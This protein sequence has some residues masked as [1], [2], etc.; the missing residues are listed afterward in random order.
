MELEKLE[1]F[2]DRVMSDVNAAMSCLNLYIG[3]RLNLFQAL[4]LL[5]STDPKGLADY[6]HTNERY[7]KEWLECLAAG[8]YIDHDH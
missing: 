7:I 1:K 5:G 3:H 2:T 6:S 8:A 4:H